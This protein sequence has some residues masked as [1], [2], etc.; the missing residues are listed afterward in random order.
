VV[1]YGRYYRPFARILL[2]VIYLREKKPEESQKL[3]AELAR[4]FPANQLI[5]MELAKVTEQVQRAATSG[6]KAQ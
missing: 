5:R 4:D 1:K 2:S 3:L 6:G